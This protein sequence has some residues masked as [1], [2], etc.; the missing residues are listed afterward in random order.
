M[1]TDVC[2]IFLARF[3]RSRIGITTIDHPGTAVVL[4][5]PCQQ[6]SCRREMRSCINTCYL[7][8]INEGKQSQITPLL[9]LDAGSGTTHAHTGYR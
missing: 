6:N 1:G 4:T 2:R 8:T 7:R 3:T 9:V 5:R